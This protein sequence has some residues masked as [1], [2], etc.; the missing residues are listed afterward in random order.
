M[1]SKPHTNS[2][3]RQSHL[4]LVKNI[5]VHLIRIRLR[6][7]MASRI[8]PTGP[9]D[10]VF[11][12]YCLNMTSLSIPLI[13]RLDPA[14]RTTSPRQTT[15]NASFVPCT[16]ITLNHAFLV[17]GKL[18]LQNIYWPKL[19]PKFTINNYLDPFSI[20]IWDS[21]NTIHEC[22]F[23]FFRTW[24]LS[25]HLESTQLFL[26]HKGLNN[27]IKNGSSLSRHVLPQRGEYQAVTLNVPSK[28]NFVDS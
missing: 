8:F 26:E 17:A 24:R 10:V 19:S 4:Q 15:T 13:S 27:I 5:V 11:S 9:R 22:Q 3:Q 6:H 16:F 1:K 21:W 20:I 28:I 12:M 23:H 2:Q 14:S 7:K 25:L 18:E